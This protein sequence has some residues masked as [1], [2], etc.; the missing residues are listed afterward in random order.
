[1]KYDEIGNED[2]VGYRFAV[3]SFDVEQSL[4][5]FFNIQH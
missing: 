2:Y 5:I 4:F 3:L 1:M